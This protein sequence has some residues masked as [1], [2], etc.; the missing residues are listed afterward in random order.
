MPL[1]CS[2]ITGL[3]TSKGELG[4]PESSSARVVVAPVKS[5]GSAQPA[6]QP[7]GTVAGV[8]G[9]GQT[10]ASCGEASAPGL[11]TLGLPW[12][13]TRG[14]A[15]LGWVGANAAFIAG[16]IARHSTAISE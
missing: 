13:H 14:S 11:Y 5:P 2:D 3:L 7:A 1:R 15:L 8:G 9:R 6:D 12:Q 10:L 4:G 16:H